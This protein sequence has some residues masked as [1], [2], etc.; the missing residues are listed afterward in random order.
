M[1]HATG[2][3]TVAAWDEDTYQELDGDAKLTKATVTFAMTGDI[4]GEASMGRGDVLPARRDGGLHRV[5]SG[6]QGQLAG[7]DGSFV[8]LRR[9]RVRG[10]RGA[11]TLAGHRGLGHWRPGRPDG[12]RAG[13]R[14]SDSAG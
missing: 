13:R 14:D 10:G 8:V 7:V 1:A 4:T 12:Q 11:L 3:F 5:S 9:R 2:T 6:L